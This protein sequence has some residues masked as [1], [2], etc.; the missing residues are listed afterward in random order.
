MLQP[1]RVNLIDLSDVENM[2]VRNLAIAEM[3]RGILMRQQDIYDAAT[4]DK[5]EGADVNPLMTK[6]HRGGSRILSDVLGLV[7]NWVIYKID[8]ATIRRLKSYIPN[9][10]ESLR[11]HVR[12]LG[13]GQA[14]VS[15]LRRNVGRHSHLERYAEFQSVAGGGSRTRTYEGLA[16][17]FT[18][19]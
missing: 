6:F 11:T 17:G 16:S 13:P 2:D 15:M 8:E 4:K 18:V 10:D 1:G 5:P 9:S 3:L 7:N 12:A 14:L 19:R